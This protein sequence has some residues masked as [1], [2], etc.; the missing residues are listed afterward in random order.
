MLQG[1]NQC[2]PVTERQQHPQE[3]EETGKRRIRKKKTERCD[4]YTLCCS[5]CIR[6][7]S[8]WI[9]PR[10]H[11]SALPLTGGPLYPRTQRFISDKQ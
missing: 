3:Q 9:D 5:V 2:A 4:K 6:C 11:L 7:V 8:V 10:S 1:G